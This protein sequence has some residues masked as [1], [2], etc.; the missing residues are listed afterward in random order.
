MI[1]VFIT[2]T[3]IL[4]PPMT[5]V[6]MVVGIELS[7]SGQT[8]FLTFLLFDGR[9]TAISGEMT[10]VREVTDRKVRGSNPTSASRLPLSRLGQPGC[11]PALVLPS[12]SMAVRHRK[13]AT[14]ERYIRQ[15]RFE[16]FGNNQAGIISTK[17]CSARGEKAQWLE[18]EFTDRKARIRIRPL[19]LDITFLGLGNLA[20]SQPSCFLRMVWK[21]GTEGC[22]S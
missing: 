2:E 5:M 21:L 20:V 13:G 11:I 15:F 3:E 17:R 12:G 14:A 16:R 1:Q 19:P 4:F 10:Q 6:T 18:R 9:H 7:S 8:V 22:Y